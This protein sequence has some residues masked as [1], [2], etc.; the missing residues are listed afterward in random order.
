M[1]QALPI[2]FQEHLQ[3]KEK[4]K[5]HHHRKKKEKNSL[6]HIGA[7]EKTDAPFDCESRAGVMEFLAISRALRRVQKIGDSWLGKIAQFSPYVCVRA[8]DDSSAALASSF[9]LD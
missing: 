3:V 7:T 5:V 2:R 1:T 6:I 8:C 4:L 9:S